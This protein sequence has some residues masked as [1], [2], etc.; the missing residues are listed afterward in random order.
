MISLVFLRFLHRKF[1]KLP[2]QAIEA[3][4]AGLRPPNGGQQYP[5]EASRHFLNIV[6]NS[7]SL[8]TRVCGIRKDL[9]TFNFQKPFLKSKHT[10]KILVLNYGTSFLFITSWYARRWTGLLV[11]QTHK[12]NLSWSIL[13]YLQSRRDDP[14]IWWTDIW[15]KIGLVQTVKTHFT[16]YCRKYYPKITT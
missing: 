6:N 14:R 9:V 2:A 8:S 1:S 11:W 15:P 3:R 4:L 10:F 7:E 5:K 13:T 12:S 16:T